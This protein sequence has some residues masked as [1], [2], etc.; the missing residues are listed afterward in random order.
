MPSRSLQD[1]DKRLVDRYLRMAKEFEA[2]TGH[3]LVVTCTYRSPEEQ[4]KLYA[5][6]RGANGQIEDVTKVVTYLSGEPGH[7]S[8]HNHK[9]S[10]ALDVAVCVGGKAIWDERAYWPLVHLTQ[11]VNLESGGG[12]SSFRDWPHVQ[13]P[14]SDA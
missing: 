1:A 13:L 8:E 5:L 14:R 10:R 11:T 12:W 4:K 3:T 2:T 6:G 7:L 9:P